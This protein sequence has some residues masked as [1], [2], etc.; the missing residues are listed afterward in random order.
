MRSEEHQPAQL[1]DSPDS[2]RAAGVANNVS[3]LEAELAVLRWAP[4]AVALGLAVRSFDGRP[5]A[6]VDV[7]AGGGLWFVEVKAVAPFG[8]AS[9]A[10]VELRAQAAR[11]ATCACAYHVGGRQPALLYVFTRGCSDEV[12]P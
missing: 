11:L 12:Q 9:S 7:V 4:D 1:R 8:L 10:W 2:V 3:G 6:S 5:S